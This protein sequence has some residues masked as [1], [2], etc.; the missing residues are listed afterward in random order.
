VYSERQ[1]GE[2]SLASVSPCPDC[3]TDGQLLADVAPN[4]RDR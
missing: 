3:D 4:V 2:I 1:A